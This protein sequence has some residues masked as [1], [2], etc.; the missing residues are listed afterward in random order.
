MS[1]SKELQVDHIPHFPGLPAEVK[2]SINKKT[3]RAFIK[4]RPGKGGKSFSYVDVGYV[5]A[6][7]NN[8]FN[9]MWSFE[10]VR[11]DLKGN[12]V[13]VLGKLSV[14]LPNGKELVRMQYGSAEV[15][16]MRNS[17]DAVDYGNDMKA[18]ASDALKKCAS[19]LG[20]CHDIYHPDVHN[21]VEGIKKNMGNA[22]PAEPSGG[23]G[24]DRVSSSGDVLHTDVL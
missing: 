21:T 9:H 15:K 7:L 8:I 13:W 5:T 14:P 4:Q 20:F 24:G 12:Q 19:Q 16:K 22:A 18:A 23:G 6:Q 10:V 1:E 11:E 17:N 3:P 2:E